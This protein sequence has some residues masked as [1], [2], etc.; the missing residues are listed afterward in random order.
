MGRYIQP[1]GWKELTSQCVNSSVWPPE[2]CGCS[3]WPERCIYGVRRCVCAQLL[4]PVI[5]KRWEVSS[6]TT[7]CIFNR[8]LSSCQ[9]PVMTVYTT[10]LTVTVFLL[11]CKC[12]SK[13]FCLGLCPWTH[14]A[15]VPVNYKQVRSE[16]Q[17][18]ETSYF[19]D[20]VQVMHSPVKCK[21]KHVC[22]VK[23][24]HPDTRPSL[25]D[26]CWGIS[27]IDRWSPGVSHGR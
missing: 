20:L 9:S 14:S 17:S 24:L 18:S 25:T 8:P 5:R 22:R 4:K 15:P 10:T 12:H 21:K 6:E 27:V 1:A 2:V 23:I 13:H 16:A 26:S 11:G 3:S 19:L 7:R